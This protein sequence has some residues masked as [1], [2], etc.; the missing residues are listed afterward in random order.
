[1]TA[2]VVPAI[3]FRDVELAF[4]D[5]VVL[6]KVSFIGPAGRDEDRPRR[7]GQR[8]IDHHQPYPRPVKT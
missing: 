2:A 4:D 5:Q 1:M 6:D 3:E 7:F 8:K